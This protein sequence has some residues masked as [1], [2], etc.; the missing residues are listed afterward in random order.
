MKFI[1]VTSIVCSLHA[2]L[3]VILIFQS[4]CRTV[5]VEQV[6]N[7]PYIAD[8]NYAIK[9]D[10]YKEYEEKEVLIQ[11]PIITPTC[12]KS[13][14]SEDFVGTTCSRSLRN[15]STDDFKSQPI[16]ETLGSQPTNNCRFKPTRPSKDYSFNE[17]LLTSV[18]DI[19]APKTCA[20]SKGNSLGSQETSYTVKSGDSLWKIAQHQKI[21]VAELASANVI[22]R[23][24]VL[25]VGQKLTIPV[26]KN[27]VEIASDS[28]ASVVEGGTYTIRKGDTLS[29]IAH[30]FKV[31]L[32]A[33]KKANG[34]KNN[35]IVAGKKIIIPGVNSQAIQ[36]AIPIV[37]PKSVVSLS[38]EG[39]Y[40]VQNGDSLSVIANRFGV[41]VADL[42]VWNKMTDAKKLRS[43]QA[44]IVSN[45]NKNEV[46]MV[47]TAHNNNLSSTKIEL[48]K[49]V[50]SSNYSPIEEEPVSF[51]FFEDDDLFDIS[52]EIPIVSTTEV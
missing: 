19:E 1:K 16:V 32:E 23:D 28:S 48:V 46:P 35:I 11:D 37:Q 34:I 3:A 40:Q 24:A 15:Q 17:G 6:N 4:G 12:P 52:D 30:R 42:M 50:S 33:I 14:K 20:M 51:D 45:N 2:C 27:I 44:L 36:V 38:K 9:A 49:P 29:E 26:K 8:E 31:S 39:T 5:E 10:D 22:N 18:K 21:S 13:F 41:T 7:A 25:K 47:Q 43:G